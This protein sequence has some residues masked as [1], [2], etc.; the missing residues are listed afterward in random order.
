MT[1]TELNFAIENA[2]TNLYDLNQQLFDYW[3]SELYNVDDSVIEE[4][5]TAQNLKLIESDVFQNAN[6]CS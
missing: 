3:Y 2:L 1:Q 4:S 5:W 6:L